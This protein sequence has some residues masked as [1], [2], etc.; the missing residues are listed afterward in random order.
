MPFTGSHP[1]AVLPFLRWG[2]VPSA[3]VIGSMVPD[4][5]YF[6]RLPVD[7]MLTH[8]W[9]GAVTVDVALGAVVF[10]V[11]QDMLAPALLAIAPSGVRARLD[12]SLPVGVVEHVRT[13]RAAA[14]AVSLAVGA[15]T[16][17]TWDAFTHADRWG[18]THI[19][20]LA[21]R[22]GALPGYRWAQ[23]ASGVIGAVLIAGFLIRWYRR[24]P[25]E[26]AGSRR[27]PA[28][29]RV[30]AGAVWALLG[31][32]AL[33]GA[34]VGARKPLFADGGPDL[35]EASVLAATSGGSAAGVTA[36]VLAIV[37][38]LRYRRGSP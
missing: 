29:P 22:Q 30:V 36:F 2:L 25:P 9:H 17:V 12:P 21:E 4:L 5:P 13:V 3:L 20:W 34:V 27:V 8:S 31:L 37:W 1:A 14:A 18:S 16:H 7:E 24:T 10:V 26:N 23:Y 19:A 11:W 32:V 38:T 28:L 15:L 35:R 6:V 33:V